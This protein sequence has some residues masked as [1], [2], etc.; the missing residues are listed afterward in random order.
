MAATVEEL[1]INY[2]EEGIQLVKE[3]EKVILSRGPWSTILFRYQ[4]L[5]KKTNQF[6]PEKFSLRRYKKKGDEYW[7]QSKFTISSADQARK[8]IDN[9]QRWIGPETK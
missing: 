2:E 5:D 4:D 7:Q 1:S 6:G 3:I 8:I 9:L